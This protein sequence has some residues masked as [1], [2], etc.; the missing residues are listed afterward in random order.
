MFL[1]PA[2]IQLDNNLFTRGCPITGTK[3]L[4]VLF[5][6][7]DSLEPKPAAMITNFN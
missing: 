1:I 3:S 5:D 2:S 4:G 7:D 6:T